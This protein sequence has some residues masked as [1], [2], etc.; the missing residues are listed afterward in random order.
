MFAKPTISQSMIDAVSSI[1]SENEK[2]RLI[3]DA[4]MD[5]TG[6]HKAAH[7]AKKAGQSHFEFQGKKYPAT[8]KSHKEAIEMEENAFDY[9]SPRPVEPKGG[10]GVKLGSRYGGGKQKEKPEHDEPKEKMKKESFRD[11]ATQVLSGE[12]LDEADDCVTPPQAKSIAKKEVGKHEKG[13]HGKKGEVAKHVKS[14]HKEDFANTL[15]AY[16][17]YIQENKATG[18]EPVF[19]DNNM[20][21]ESKMSDAQMKKREKIVMSMKDKTSYF[22]KKYGAKWKNVMYATA[23]KQ[24]MGEELNYEEQEDV[25]QINEYGMSGPDYQH[26]DNVIQ[27]GHESDDGR[28]TTDMLRGRVEGG[29]TNDFRSFKVKLKTGSEKPVPE[30]KPGED[31]KEKQKVS[32]QSGVVDIKFDDKLGS[33]NPYTYFSKDKQ[34]K[35]EEVEQVDEK[36]GGTQKSLNQTTHK[37]NDPMR[38]LKVTTDHPRFAN[39]PLNKTS[40]DILKNRLKSAQGTHSKPNLPEEVDL[41]EDMKSLAKKAFKALTGGSDKDQRKDLQRKMGVP[42]TGNKP[43]QKEDAGVGGSKDPVHKIGVRGELKHIRSKEAKQDG[44]ELSQFKKDHAPGKLVHKEE[45][46]G[47]SDTARDVA[48]KAFKKLRKETM[49]GKISN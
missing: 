1:I 33:P 8:A 48:S 38:R 42:Q 39:K 9:K 4:E 37:T 29:E 26:D 13:M 41:E 35:N 49:M 6:F 14:M 11:A 19:T 25:E 28:V 45:K 34:V 16:A 21:E 7:A 44:A 15:L 18:T 47:P 36:F 2:K 43:L 31:T 22:K 40:Q 24:A 32:T 17:K 23:T 46:V 12:V 30:H 20:G 10:S 27:Q 5:E 3:N